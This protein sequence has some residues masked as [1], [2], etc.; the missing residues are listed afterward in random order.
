M[1]SIATRL[2]RSARIL[3]FA[4]LLALAGCDGGGAPPSVSGSNTEVTVH[5]TVKYK[6]QPV[7]S[8]IVQFDPANINRRDA[9]GVNGPIDKEGKFTVKTLIGENRVTFKD[10]PANV[11]KDMSAMSTTLLYDAPAGESTYDIDL[12]NK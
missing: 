8:G 12:G 9:K 6:G 11:Q 10:L 1:R 5:G 2:C 4:A 3:P 7:T